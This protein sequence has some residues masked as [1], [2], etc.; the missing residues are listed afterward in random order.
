VD[1]GGRETKGGLVQVGLTLDP[2]DLELLRREA[3][4]RAREREGA[5]TDWN[6]SELVRLAI[7]EWL[8]KHGRAK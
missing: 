2:A 1:V 6:V 5:R 8:A 4:R 3:Q 7:R